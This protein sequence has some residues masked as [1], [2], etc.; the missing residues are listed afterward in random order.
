MSLDAAIA[1]ALDQTPHSDPMEVG[2]LRPEL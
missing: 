1:Y 2:P